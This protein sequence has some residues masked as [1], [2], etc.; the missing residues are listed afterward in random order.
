MLRSI[1][2]T[3]SCLQSDNGVS[4]SNNPPARNIVMI[5]PDYYIETYIRKYQN[6]TEFCFTQ[7]WKTKMFH[8]QKHSN[9]FLISA[10]TPMTIKPKHYSVFSID[11]FES[12]SVNP[13]KY[14]SENK[15]IKHYPREKSHQIHHYPLVNFKLPLK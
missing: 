14:K 13:D 4:T 9:P 2:S 15:E 6:T 5:Y 1:F 11:H 12:N 8:L 7:L 3:D 10:N